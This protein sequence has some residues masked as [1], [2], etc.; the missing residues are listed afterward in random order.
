VQFVVD[1]DIGQVGQANQQAV[2]AFFQH[3]CPEAEA[4]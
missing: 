4:W 1:V 3:H 2:A